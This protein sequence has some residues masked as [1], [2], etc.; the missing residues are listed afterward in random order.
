MP[1][2]KYCNESIEWATTHDKKNLPV[3]EESVYHEDL[4][5]G[6]ELL[7]AGGQVYKKVP[8]QNF[9]HV[10]GRMIHRCSKLPVNFKE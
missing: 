7:T 10:R 4:K 9:P 1:K 3:Y 6:E 2:C 8:T 5:D